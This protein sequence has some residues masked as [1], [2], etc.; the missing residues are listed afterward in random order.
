VRPALRLFPLASAAAV[1]AATLMSASAAHA[2]AD[3]AWGV[4]QDKPGRHDGEL[5][6]DLRDYWLRSM[7][8]F[9]L[10]DPTPIGV[11]SVGTG[12]LPSTGEQ[13]FLALAID[14]KYIY[15]QRFEFPIFGLVGGGAVG[16]SPRVVSSVDGTMVDMKP[17]TAGAFT[18][19]LPGVGF[20]FRERRWMFGANVR[21]VATLVWEQ[22]TFASGASKDDS[23]PA[24]WAATFGA[25]AHVE[26]CRRLDLESR[27]CL[28]VE[29]HLYEFSALNGGSAGL[30][31]EFGK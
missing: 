23:P 18:F 5:S 26:A 17:W 3:R 20:R 2:Q 30:R 8:Q 1:V 9:S 16:Q 25:R 24:L 22:V 10:S 31:W 28:F 7:P 15:N 11:R 6:F 19:L 12:T 29:P 14:T 21:M 13:H 27:L 4:T